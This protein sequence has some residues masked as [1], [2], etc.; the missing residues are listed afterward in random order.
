MVELRGR[1]PARILKADGLT[2]DAI[3]TQL[4]IGRTSVFRILRDFQTINS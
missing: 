3:A 4:G 2:A 1:Y